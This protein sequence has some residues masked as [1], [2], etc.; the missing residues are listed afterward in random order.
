MYDDIILLKRQAVIM[1]EIDNEFLELY[2]KT[3]KLF[4]NRL[5]LAGGIEEYIDQMEKTPDLDAAAVPFW[6]EDYKTLRKFR[7][8]REKLEEDPDGNV[9]SDFDMSEFYSFYSRIFVGNDALTV[10]G[11]IRSGEYKKVDVRK[12]NI[13][14]SP[15]E[16]TDGGKYKDLPP[17]VKLLI[18]LL[19]LGCTALVIFII[20]YMYIN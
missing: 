7:S 18:L 4:I 13:G 19:A 15:M 14:L 17:E 20:V 12:L 6:H 8:F 10:L 5:S 9:C 16:E 11:K 2:K 1:T 3:D